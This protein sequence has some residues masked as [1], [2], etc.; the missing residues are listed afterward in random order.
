[1]TQ[2]P[3]IQFNKGITSK[4]YQPFGM[5]LSDSRSKCSWRTFGR[6][7]RV[8]LVHNHLVMV[9]KAFLTWVTSYRL[10]NIIRDMGKE[11]GMLYRKQKDGSI[12]EQK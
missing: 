10:A 8:V 9:F 2:R 7:W 11:Y 5:A 3:Q 1:M 4:E 12:T 6:T